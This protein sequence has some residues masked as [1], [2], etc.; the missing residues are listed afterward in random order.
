MKSKRELHDSTG[1]N[2]GLVDLLKNLKII[3]LG[4]L[5]QL[6]IELVLWIAKEAC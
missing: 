5:L 6:V 2:L 4:F 1:G 3:K